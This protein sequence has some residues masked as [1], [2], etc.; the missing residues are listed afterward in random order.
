[1]ETSERY[2]FDRLKI[3]DFTVGAVASGTNAM[4][5]F[6]DGDYKDAVLHLKKTERELKSLIKMI[7]EV[8]YGERELKNEE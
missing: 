5:A 2:P 3:F 4:M 7:E 6:S 1:M 8:H